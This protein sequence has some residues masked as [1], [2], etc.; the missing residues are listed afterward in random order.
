VSAAAARRRALSHPF[1]FSTAG[2]QVAVAYE[3]LSWKRVRCYGWC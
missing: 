1:E 3:G 2:W